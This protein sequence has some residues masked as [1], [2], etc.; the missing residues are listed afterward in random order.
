MFK[1]RPFIILFLPSIITLTGGAIICS[2]KP[3]NSFKPHTSSITAD[4]G[5]TLR[6]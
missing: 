3:P 5:R 4:T 2:V 6:T 1:T